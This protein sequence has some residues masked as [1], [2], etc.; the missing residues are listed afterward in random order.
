MRLAGCMSSRDCIARRLR[1]VATYLALYDMRTER[2]R[3]NEYSTLLSTSS[4]SLYRT[5]SYRQSCIL[6]C[7]IPYGT[8]SGGGARLVCVTSYHEM[9]TAE[10]RM[11]VRPRMPCEPHELIGSD[12]EW[13]RIKIAKNASEAHRRKESGR[14][15]T[16]RPQPGLNWS[17]QP[18]VV[19]AAVE[20]SYGYHI[21]CDGT[22]LAVASRQYVCIAGGK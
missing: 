6:Q 22:T 20:C 21:K 5:C 9:I 4:L 2:E 8:Q 11:D 17:T 12:V 10:S 16:S 18:S 19:A 13:R 3:R 14:R 15:R 7:H 1:T